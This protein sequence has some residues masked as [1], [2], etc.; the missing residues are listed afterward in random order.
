MS[1]ALDFMKILWR[2]TMQGT[3]FSWQR[4]NGAMGTALETAITAGLLFDEDDFSEIFNSM[5]GVYWFSKSDSHSYGERFYTIAINCGNST[6]YKSFEA[7]KKRK[8]Y[9]IDGKRL[10]K[11]H[12][13]TWE[14][15]RVEVTSFSQDQSCVTACHYVE[16]NDTLGRKVSRVFKIT[17]KMIYDRNK[18]IRDAANIKEV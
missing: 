2:G 15:L 10:H 11:G 14:N 12:Y 9:I 1:D 18:C 17:H 13:F 4:V 16:N 3:A 6:A 7:W 5:R 8:P